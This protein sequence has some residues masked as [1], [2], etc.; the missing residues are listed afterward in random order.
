MSRLLRPAFLPLAVVASA[1]ACTGR[2]SPVVSTPAEPS[3][4][5]LVLDGV[6]SEE[7][8]SDSRVSDL[9]GET[10]EAY[11]SQTWATL[12]PHMATLRAATNAG[13]TITAGGHAQMVTSRLDPYANFPES[14]GPGLYRPEYPTIFEE[15]R[16]Q[17]GLDSTQAQFLGNT[18]LLQ[19]EVQS[20]Q[21]GSA[22]V[23]GAYTLLYDPSKP[24]APINDDTPMATAV[25]NAVKTDRP[26]LLVANFHD[27][28]RAGHY[29]AGNAYIDDVKKL[30]GLLPQLWDWLGKNDP[31]YRDNLLLIITADHGRHRHDED[32]GWHNHGDSC[33]GCRQIPLMILGPGVTPGAELAG[34]WTLLDFAPTLAAH[35]GIDLPWAQGLPIDEVVSN[36]L[37][38]SGDVGLSADGTAWTHYL[39]DDFARDQVVVDGAVVSTE[40]AMFAEGVRAAGIVTNTGGSAGRYACWR[41]LNIDETQLYWPWSPSCRIDT[42]SGFVDSGFAETEVGLNWAPTVVQSGS[43]LWAVY[44][45][46]PDG[47]GEL[48]N[49]NEVGLRAASWS[50]TTGWGTPVQSPQLFPTDPVAIPTATG[51][52]AAVGTNLDGDSARNTRRVRVLPLIVRSDGATASWGPAV[53]IDLADVLD[54]ARVER[55]ALHQRSDGTIELAVVATTATENVVALLQSTDGGASFGPATIV[56][57]DPALPQLSPQFSGDDLLWAALSPSGDSELCTLHGATATCKDV[58]SARLDSY[59]ALTSA[60]IIDTGTAEWAKTSL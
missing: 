4:M 33:N 18:E 43:T 34:N 27:V 37:T 49:S 53:D 22:D 7:F 44:N 59:S 40:G 48:G 20:I 2:G 30:D 21:P 11:A 41:E 31:G 14:D 42:G 13:V 23:A 28:D 35:L 16:G 54:S 10:G 3:V 55:P 38:R 50:P 39:D 46:N 24:N 26:R 58:R 60:A 9:T 15:L 47:I 6:R 17:L 1:V 12:G 25:E 52:L 51:L 5:I 32:N 45:H 57:T 56:S 29:G 8:T 36:G 19:G